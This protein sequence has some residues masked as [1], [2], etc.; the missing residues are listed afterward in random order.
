MRICI[1]YILFYVATG[2]R[3]SIHHVPYLQYK[4]NNV[5]GEHLFGAVCSGIFD[6]RGDILVM[7]DNSW[8]IGRT[9]YN[10]QKEFLIQLIDRLDL[11]NVRLSAISYSGFP[12][13]EF[14]FNTARPKTGAV[15]NVRY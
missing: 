6:K 13:T 9:N 12:K 1:F 5:R 2:G 4:G 15:K 10:F 8:S 3:K 7:L 11:K 14:Y